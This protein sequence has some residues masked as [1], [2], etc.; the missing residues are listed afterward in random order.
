MAS[1]STA[2]RS[3]WSLV[4]LAL[5]FERPMH[6]Y[7]MRRLV[8]QRGKGELVDLRPGSL[9][10]TIER[11]ERARL[12][13]P[14]ETTR[15]GR[16]PERTVYRL[17][18][19]GREELEE[20]MRELLST[21]MKDF[22]RLL[23]ALSVLAV[24]EPDDARLQLESRLLRLE[25]EIAGME[26]TLGRLDGVLPRLFLLEAEYALALRKAERDWVTSLVEDL[27]AR[28][29]TWSHAELRERYGDPAAMHAFELRVMD[30][31]RA[32]GETMA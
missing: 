15:E 3:P 12:V 26:T 27:R 19:H 9:Y 2:Y 20:W 28:R 32:K 7:E 13:E 16:F 5:L 24:L 14:V 17:T 22:P 8:R 18:D 29:L 21:P 11:L 30:G 10:R 4:V 25:G 31:Q 1:E 6:P 23:E